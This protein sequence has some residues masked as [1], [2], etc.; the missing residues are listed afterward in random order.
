MNPTTLSH[1]GIVL[2]TENVNT[3]VVLQVMNLQN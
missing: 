1:K 3:P 2:T